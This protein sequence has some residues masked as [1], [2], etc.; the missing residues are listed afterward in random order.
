MSSE[1]WL[2]PILNDAVAERSNSIRITAPTYGPVSQ[3]S[4]LRE[5]F[6][7]ARISVRAFSCIAATTS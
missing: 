3:K 6:S 2:T 7:Y 5:S 4:A 1:N